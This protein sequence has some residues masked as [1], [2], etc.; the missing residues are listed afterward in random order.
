[1]PRETLKS[2][3]AKQMQ[4]LSQRNLA[5]HDEILREAWQ[6]KEEVPKSKETSKPKDN[7]KKD[8]KDTDLLDDIEEEEVDLEI[9]Q[10]DITER[11][12]LIEELMR[13]LR[14]KQ[15]GKHVGSK[16]SQRV[17]QRSSDFVYQKAKHETYKE[18]YGKKQKFRAEHPRTD[19]FGRMVKSKSSDNVTEEISDKLL[20]GFESERLKLKSLRA[21]ETSRQADDRELQN[22]NTHQQ[23]R[24]KG[25]PHPLTFRSEQIPQDRRNHPHPGRHGNY[26]MNL[27]FGAK[28]PEGDLGDNA[29]N[30]RT[31]RDGFN[32]RRTQGT[33]SHYRY[34]PPEEEPF[35]TEID[36]TSHQPLTSRKNYE[37]TQN[38][39]PQEDKLSKTSVP[40]AIVGP[41]AKKSPEKMQLEKQYPIRKQPLPQIQHQDRSKPNSV[42]YPIVQSGSKSI[43]YPAIVYP[44]SEQYQE[45]N[46]PVNAVPNDK[47]GNV[48]KHY[49]VEA[50]VQLS[51]IREKEPAPRH[52]VYKQTGN[53]NADDNARDPAS[54][55]KNDTS[56]A[57]NNSYSK[58]NV[59]LGQNDENNAD[60]N[61]DATENV[62]ATN[63]NGNHDYNRKQNEPL[64]DGSV[65]D[66][67]NEPEDRKQNIS[68]N[69]SLV[70]Q[71]ESKMNV[72]ENDNNDEHDDF[73][74]NSNMS[75][76]VNTLSPSTEDRVSTKSMPKTFTRKPKVF[77]P[78]RKNLK[79]FSLADLLVTRPPEKPVIEQ[80]VLMKNRRVKFPHVER[81]NTQFPVYKLSPSS[82]RV[83]FGP[84]STK[85][86]HKNDLYKL[87]DSHSIPHTIPNPIS[88]PNLSS[89]GNPYNQESDYSIRDNIKLEIDV[90]DTKPDDAKIMKEKKKIKRFWEVV[91]GREVEN[92]AELFGDESKHDK[93]LVTKVTKQR[94]M[95][96]KSKHSVKTNSSS[97]HQHN[98]GDFNVTVEVA[99]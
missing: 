67:T 55:E 18:K 25:E 53:N 77:K 91:G 85:T 48:V 97:V 71:D 30:A 20:A 4:Q 59:E 44:D 21:S 40:T 43:Q 80:P 61:P 54:E 66:V 75:V 12:R 83:S 64:N 50:V 78:P 9:L 14:E 35:Q 6:Q 63:I 96:A 31:S 86:L 72:I 37:L 51:P 24:T 41:F 99:N 58:Q 62:L 16:R 19:P 42:Q 47:D 70:G 46:Y 17:F 88:Q 60:T 7:P 76:D 8:K 87:Y 79:K 34:L 27:E 89:I 94:I 95:S 3:A 11:E 39:A 84:N 65:I 98:V 32:T 29:H 38:V 36:Y 57:E 1:M 82:K 5:K 28:Y 33:E 56:H 49:S 81:V 93:V 45:Y 15:R 69:I 13:P 92:E 2:K 52:E 10:A 90:V 22:V 23:T 73:S 68:E 26:M 74:D